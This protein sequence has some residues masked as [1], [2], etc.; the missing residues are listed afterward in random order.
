MRLII[1][2]VFILLA[3]A[4]PALSQPQSTAKANVDEVL[5]DL[6]VR[7]KKGKPITDLKREEIAITDNG[8]KQSI[9]SFR[10]V[11]GSEAV[12]STG[13]SMPLDPLRQIRLVTLAFEPLAAPDQRKLARSAALDLIKGDQGVNVFYSVV[14]IDTRLLVLQHFTKDRSAL[15]KA[16]ERA[17][18]GVSAPRL[19]SESDAIVAQLKRRLAGPSVNGADQDVNLL[20]AATQVAELQPG[21]G[22]DPTLI[23]L[24]RTMLDM[25]RMD[26]SVQSNGARLSLSALRAL[27]D[28]LREMPGRKSVLYFTS[29]M[30][31]G[32]ELDMPFRNLVA[33]ANRDN[34]T[35]YSV[36]VRGVRVSSQNND[37][38]NQL[39]AGAQSSNTTTASSK[40]VTGAAVTKDQMTAADTIET[41]GRANLDLPI[42]DLAESTGGFL[43]GDSNDLRVPLR[44]VNEEIGSYYEIS[45]NPAIENYDASF[46]KLAVATTR[47]DVVIHARTGYFALPPGAVAAGLAPFEMPLLKTISDGKLSEDVK[48]RA[49]A[50]LLQPGKDTT[51]VAVLLEVPLHELQATTTPNS[52]DVHCTLAAL[53]KDSK[54]AL[55][56]KITRD[57]SFKVTADQHNMGNF[58]D[59]TILNLAPGKYTLDSAVSDLA[60]MKIGMQHLEFTVPAGG[61]GVG[62]SGL[63]PMRSY[64]PNAK[65][66]DPD[67]PF[68]FQGGSL[69]PTMDIAVKKVPNSV[70]RLFFTVYQDAS[71]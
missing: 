63:L 10:L 8:V 21:E 30:Y 18:E 19:A 48:Y 37:A 36:D 26:A 56:E 1:S 2:A 44:H 6:V 5:L 7:D 3:A 71:I 13:A 62:I 55:V 29:G 53:V 45:Y 34:V 38:M 22:G 12:S 51:G 11:R 17:T 27:V 59:K 70:L 52:T 50:V 68:Q 20:T 35:F 15:A 42:R 69:T 28:G 65:G 43:I 58:L 61:T 4:P 23:L 14:V 49:G 60:N 46:R 40:A 25:L 54:G 64:T 39:N 9:L 66:L 57:R 33:T 41:A 16:I 32:T 24:A 47:K 31:L 67:D